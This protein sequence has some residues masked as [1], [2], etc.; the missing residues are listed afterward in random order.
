[1]R[2]TLTFM[3]AFALTLSCGHPRPPETPQP[4]PPGYDVQI[5]VR[6]CQEDREGAP[7][8]NDFQALFCT[9]TDGGKARVRMPVRAWWDLKLR[10]I[11][12]VQKTPGK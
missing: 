5:D 8:G 10:D 4:T 1:M 11:G 9:R 6:T 3:A 12:N 7:D 2:S